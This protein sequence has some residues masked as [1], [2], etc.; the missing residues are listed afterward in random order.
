MTIILWAV[1]TKDP[2]VFPEVDRFVLL[3][4]DLNSYVDYQS[5][6]NLRHRHQLSRS[7][8]CPYNG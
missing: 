4:I 5:R 7:M 2:S 6:R 8:G 1:G 3:W